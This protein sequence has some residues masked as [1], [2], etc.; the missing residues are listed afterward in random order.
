MEQKGI[1][2]FMVT[3]G[4]VINYGEGDYK[5]GWDGQGGGRKKF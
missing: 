2:L 1:F 4:P 5:A 3:K